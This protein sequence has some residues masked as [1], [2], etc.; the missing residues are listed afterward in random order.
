MCRMRRVNCALLFENATAP[1]SL[2]SGTL[3]GMRLRG[4][5]FRTYVRANHL[6]WS[7]EMTK[8]P[9]R[10]FLRTGLRPV[11]ELIGRRNEKAVGVRATLV[12]QTMSGEHETEKS[13]AQ[14]TRRS[15]L[16]ARAKVYLGPPRIVSEPGASLTRIVLRY[17]AGEPWDNPE[18]RNQLADSIR[19]A[20]S[21]AAL[22]NEAATEAERDAQAFYLR[23]AAILQE[24]QAEVLAG[25]V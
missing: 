18:L 11:A 13:E 20:Q 15:E 1:I 6:I 3:S 12:K 24:I 19:T 9:N 16:R 21:E 7:F 14:V 22:R 8:M 10:A 2:P 25:R 17:L 4:I 23:A 5:T